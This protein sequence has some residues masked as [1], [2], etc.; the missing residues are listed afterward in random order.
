LGKH[1]RLPG[2]SSILGIGEPGLVIDFLKVSINKTIERPVPDGSVSTAVIEKAAPMAETRNPIFPKKS[3]FWIPKRS[4]N[5][6]V[7]DVLGDD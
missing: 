7:D 6:T 1:R 4:L 3:D 2:I 5:I